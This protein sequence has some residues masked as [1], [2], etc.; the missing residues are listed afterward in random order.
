MNFDLN[1]ENYTRDELIEM[2]ELPQN[3]DRNI[4]DIKEAKLNDSIINNKEINKETQVKTL[5][6]L[7]K[8][9]TIILN[10]S[11]PQKNGTFQQKIDICNFQFGWNKRFQ[12]LHCITRTFNDF[13]RIHASCFKIASLIFRTIPGPS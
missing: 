9:K 4:I 6:F 3:F 5:N 2:F 8:A 7:M 13:Y 12:S 10:D 11:K 1:I